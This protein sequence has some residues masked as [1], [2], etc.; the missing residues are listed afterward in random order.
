MSGSA[1]VPPRPAVASPPSDPARFVTGSILR[2]I[3]LMIGT[4]APGWRPA[5]RDRQPRGTNGAA[6]GLCLRLAAG[7]PAATGRREGGVNSMDRELVNRRLRG[8]RAAALALPL[9]MLSPAAPPEAAA[10]SGGLEGSWRG[11]GSVSFASG[12]H[13]RAECRAQYRRASGASYTVT[14]TCATPSGRATQTAT[15]RQVG[16]NTYQGQFH[17]SEY[18]VSGTIFVTVSGNRQSVRLMGDGGSASFELRR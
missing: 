9:L 4:S 18:D 11:G 2:H 13:E 10:Q 5:D 16:G 7:G 6:L 3:L 8:A 14:A 15:L 1:P 17:N 12:Q